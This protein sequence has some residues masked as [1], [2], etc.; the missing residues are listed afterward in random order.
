MTDIVTQCGMIEMNY[1]KE[2]IQSVYIRICED[3]SFSIDATDVAHLVAGAMNISALQVWQS[4][5][6]IKTMFQIAKGE[7]QVV[8][9]DTMERGLAGKAD[10]C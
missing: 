4:F 8:K 2:T 7:H 5:S 9:I 6:D 10:D 1:S 3:S